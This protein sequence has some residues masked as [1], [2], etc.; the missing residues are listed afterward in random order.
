[1]GFGDVI[2]GIWDDYGD[3]LIRAGADWLVNSTRS[4]QPIVHSPGRRPTTRS[5]Q[6]FY[7]E[8]ATY[9]L[10]GGFA[11]VSDYRQ[12][13]GS[14]MSQLGESAVGHATHSPLFTPTRTSARP[15]S[16]VIVT[17]PVTGKPTFFKHAGRPILF[18]GDLRAA[19][20][21]QKIARRAARKR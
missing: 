19:K 11:Q 2:G 4:Q 9:Q 5:V 12:D 8:P 20:R 15:S 6:P 3:D 13:L 21:V 10:P 18:S 1:M 7:A 17:N 14:M 16:L